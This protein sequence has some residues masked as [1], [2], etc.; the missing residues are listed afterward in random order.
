M[1]VYMPLSMSTTIRH[2]KI[3]TTLMN[4]IFNRIETGELHALQEECSLVYWGRSTEPT[5]V[6]LVALDKIENLQKFKETTIEDLYFVQPDLMVFK[7]NPY[8]ENLRKTKTAGQPDLIIEVWSE[9]NS[10]QERDFK[11]Y[12]YSTSDTTE[13][14]YIEQDS[15][16]VD[17]YLGKNK[18]DSQCLSNVLKSL[19]GLKFDL[20]RLAV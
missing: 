20:R 18:I 17:C 3:I 2:N 5:S 12:L 9:G 7:A 19:G 16:E 11:K 10:K 1:D 13:H 15:N 8:V 6:G 14:W 4:R